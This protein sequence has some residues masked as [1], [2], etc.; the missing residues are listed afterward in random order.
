MVA[1]PRSIDICTHTHTGFKVEIAAVPSP[2]IDMSTH[3]F[4]GGDCGCTSTKHLHEE[5]HIYQWCVLL[6]MLG[7]GAA[8]ISILKRVCAHV[9]AWGYDTTISVNPKLF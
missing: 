2:S 7:G 4:E 9:D 6:S 3:K 1:P 5:T 8:T